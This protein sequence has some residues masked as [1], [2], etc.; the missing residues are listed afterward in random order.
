[1]DR[2]KAVT[3][4]AELFSPLSLGAVE[5]ANRITMAPLYTGYANQKG[6][7]TP[8]M[9][10][11]YQEM[12]SSGAALVVVENAAVSV[13]GMGSPFALR[14]D[15]DCFC[16]GLTRLSQSIKLGGARAGLQIN[17]AGRFAFSPEP[18]APSPVAAGKKVPQ[19][20]SQEAM[21]AITQDFAQ[22]ARRVRQAGFDLV[23][24][25]GGTGY[26]LSQFISPRTNLRSD[27]YGGPMQARMRFPLE[28]IA[29]VRQAVGPDYPI[30]YRFLA[31]EWLPQGLRL[32]QSLEAAPGLAQ[33]G[34][35]YLSVMGGTY[36]SFFL[37]EIKEQDRSPGYMTG[38]AEAVKKTVSIPVIAAGRIQTPE[39][40]EA[41]LGQGK[42]DL[43]G[44]ARVLLAD[45][46]WPRKARE[47]RASEITACEPH[48]RLCWERAFKGRPMICS[49]WTREKREQVDAAG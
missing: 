36:E 4:F 21:A 27:D 22:A 5:L 37:P 2:K 26:L 29:A 6:E 45:P 46:E 47:G 14:V 31:D 19:E 35:A 7:V 34:L 1:M 39:M 23:E 42:T 13:Q 32:E 11:H 18:V 41:L 40:A 12:G 10:S 17:H 49:Q 43:I 33:A 48:C 16:H 30:G 9:L 28:V 3:A 15:D 44:L 24:L 25:H 38:L 8:L 20:L